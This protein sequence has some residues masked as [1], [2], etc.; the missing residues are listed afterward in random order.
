MVC[1]DSGNDEEML[2]GEPLAVVVKN[3]SPELKKL[4]GLKNVY[5]SSKPCAA[6]IVDAISHY[7]FLTFKKG[8]KSQNRLSPPQTTPKTES[9][10]RPNQSDEKI[11][12]LHNHTVAEQPEVQESQKDKATN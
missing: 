3:Y 10:N 8:Q 5:F 9:Q 11:V 2:R 4:N 12:P 7:K 6:G 1:G